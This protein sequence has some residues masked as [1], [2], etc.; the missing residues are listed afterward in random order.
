MILGNIYVTLQQNML[1]LLPELSVSWVVENQPSPPLAPPLSGSTC[2][3][4]PDSS[5]TWK[6]LPPSRAAL[7]P[8][9]S[10]PSSG[11]WSFP[12]QCARHNL[13]PF[14]TKCWS[15]RPLRT[16]TMSHSSYSPRSGQVHIPSTLVWP[17][18]HSVS[19]GT[20][21]APV[22]GRCPP[23]SPWGCDP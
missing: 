7:A 19:P 2:S 3:L 5:S 17:L 1:Y 16:E 21:G 22:S 11:S 23:L 10:S 15:L 6:L 13:L 4:R 12:P 14:S 18:T 9:L 20:A 8:M